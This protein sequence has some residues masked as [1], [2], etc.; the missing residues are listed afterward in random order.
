MLPS[1][2]TQQRRILAHNRILISICANLNLASLVILNKPCPATAL[3]T[4]QCG[5]ELSFERGEIA[6]GGLDRSLYPFSV[7]QWSPDNKDLAR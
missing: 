7:S 2:H 1:I 5:V 4:C 6:V 3:D